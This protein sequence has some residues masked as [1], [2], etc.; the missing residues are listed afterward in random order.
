MFVGKAKNWSYTWQTI[1]KIMNPTDISAVWTVFECCRNR[2]CS[3]GLF[4]AHSVCCWREKWWRN[5]SLGVL[6]Y[7]WVCVS[8][9]ESEWSQS[10]PLGYVFLMLS[11]PELQSNRAGRYPKIEYPMYF[12]SCL[13][14]P[15]YTNK[16]RTRSVFNLV[17]MLNAQQS[18]I[19]ECA[20][21]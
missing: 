6:I 18:L 15:I 5:H 16:K 1:E 19:P 9:C 21:I 7:L 4:A 12:C 11:W 2:V 20:D 14:A 8:E 10:L 3:A 13:S 17:L